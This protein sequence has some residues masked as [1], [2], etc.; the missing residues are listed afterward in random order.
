M[1]EAEVYKATPIEDVACMASI[2]YDEPPAWVL[3]VE[4]ESIFRERMQE[5]NNVM[6][7][8]PTNEGKGFGV[9]VTVRCGIRS[10]HCDGLNNVLMD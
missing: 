7:S 5:L 4:K 3:V 1:S 2:E 6:A 8:D 9:L 10:A